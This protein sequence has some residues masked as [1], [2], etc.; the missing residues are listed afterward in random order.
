MGEVAARVGD[1]NNRLEGLE[2]SPTDD[3]PCMGRT[4]LLRNAGDEVLSG[5]IGS[6]LVETSDSRRIRELRFP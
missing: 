1:A 4:A 2:G 6:L 5:P 3:P